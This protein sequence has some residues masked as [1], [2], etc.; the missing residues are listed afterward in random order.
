MKKVTVGFSLAEFTDHPDRL[1]RVSRRDNPEIQA[2][3]KY[4]DD[5][6]SLL[7]LLTHTER[8]GDGSIVFSN[9][10]DWLKEDAKK[11]IAHL[12]LE[13]D[14]RM[15]LLQQI[16]GSLRYLGKLLP[17]YRGRPIDLRM[18]HA[19]EFVRKFCKLGSKP[20]SVQGVRRRLNR[21]ISFVRN[22]YPSESGNNFR[23]FFPKK[24][25]QVVGNDPLE[26]PE[27]AVISTDRVAQIIDACAADLKA[28]LEAKAVYIDKE[29]NP[30]EYYKRRCRERKL[31]Q[32]LPPRQGRPPTLIVLFS[33]AIK[34]QAV[35]LAICVGRRAASI[36]NAPY[37]VKVKKV[38]WKN[39]LGEVERGVQ[40]KLRERK[41]RNVDED[42]ACPDAFGEL[43]TKA[44]AT[45]KELT[46]E[47]RRLNPELKDF[48]FLVPARKK[49]AAVVLSQRQLIQYLNGQH[50]NGSGL[51]DRYDIPEG[52]IK[53]H[54]FRK[55]RATKAW[56]GGLSLHEVSRDLGHV[57]ADMA[58][59]FYVAGSEEAKRR[60]ESLMRHGALSG[61]L[62]EL[63]NGRET[64]NTHLG[65]RHVQIM[66]SRG[67][68]VSPTRYG[69]C[70]LLEAM[71][72]CPMTTPCYIGP[73]ARGGG[74]DHHLLSPDALPAL[75][76]DKEVVEKLIELNAPDPE[77]SNWVMNQQNLLKV[78]DGKI[79]EALTLKHRHEGCCDRE[80]GCGCGGSQ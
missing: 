44:I 42:V 10:V 53:I 33:R 36:C 23:L 45:A 9:L 30:N 37:D 71:G 66:K 14:V 64:T 3:F 41:I 57:N 29:V 55:T 7:N 59:R 8:D 51:V 18:Q 62:I 77:L 21:F 15:N 6:W 19:K 16:M 49:G 56:R 24:Y 65:S 25:T 46:S 12:W 50:G 22:Q 40:V 67:S 79:A 32:E 4:S 43:V 38:E 47:L 52:K 60:F 54:N 75:Y 69:Y 76:E 73:G 78:I 68:Q 39:D 13:T 31:E 61:A 17:N 2:A 80:G 70:S 58:A 74:C 11:Y 26:V 63:V 1:F 34:A 20:V 35:I 5:V 27:S 48:L 72:L 28:Y